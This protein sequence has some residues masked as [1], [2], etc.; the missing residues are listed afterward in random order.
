MLGVNQNR[1]DKPSNIRWPEIPIKVLGAYFGYDM[2]LYE[3]RNF[4]DE[5]DKA[6]QIINKWE[7]GLLDA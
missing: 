6:K 5:K 1:K 7:Q 3:K 4:K 2:E